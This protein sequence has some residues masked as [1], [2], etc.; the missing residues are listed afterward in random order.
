MP[1]KLV[2][3]NNIWRLIVNIT[4][5]RALDGIVKEEGLCQVYYAF[6]DFNHLLTLNQHQQKEE[7]LGLFS[8]GIRGCCES[9]GYS[10]DQFQKVEQ[11]IISNGIVF[12]DYFKEKK[13]SPDKKH[14]ARLKGYLSESFEARATYVVVSDQI[15]NTTKEILVDNI[16]FRVIDKLSWAN[17]QTINIYHINTIASYKRKKVAA[18][19]YSIDISKGIVTYHPVT[20]EGIFDYGVKLLTQL[21]R[22][23]EGITLLEQA[24]ELGHGKADNILQNLK[25][26]PEQRDKAIL[27]QIPKQR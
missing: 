9:L 3:G 17:N 5:V 24:K 21:G 7:L 22:Y 4:T 20:R 13:T 18:D 1:N 10:D 16:D 27:L 14:T 2:I 15:L 25:I 23:G 12:S 19:Y 8:K 6:C 11:K 26:N